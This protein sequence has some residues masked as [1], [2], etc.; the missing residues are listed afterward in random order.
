MAAYRKA[1]GYASNVL[2][3]L[4]FGPGVAAHV[5]AALL[6]EV[7]ARHVVPLHHLPTA[8]GADC[9]VRAT[10]EA[11]AQVTNLRYPNKT[12]ETQE[13]AGLCLW[14]KQGTARL[15]REEGELSSR[16]RDS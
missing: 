10:G 1:S 5:I 6:P 16:E 12:V 14:G 4:F 3:V 9:S 2:P 15:R 7:G 8:S 11:R 13:T